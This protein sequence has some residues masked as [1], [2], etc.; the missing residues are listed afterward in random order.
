MCLRVYSCACLC[1][2]LTALS[3]NSTQS[4]NSLVELC[5]KLSTESVGPPG[6]GQCA[7]VAQN[8]VDLFEAECRRLRSVSVCQ[9]SP[10]CAWSAATQS[11]AVSG[12]TAARLLFIVGSV[13]LAVNLSKSSQQCGRMGT[14]SSAAG[15]ACA[16]GC[17]YLPSIEMCDA[18][19]DAFAS[20]VQPNPPPAPEPGA[21]LPNSAT[22][23]V[24]LRCAALSFAQ[25]CGHPCAWNQALKSCDAHPE[26]L[27]SLGGASARVVDVACQKLGVQQCGNRNDCTWSQCDGACRIAHSM[28]D[29][30]SSSTSCAEDALAMELASQAATKCVG[31]SVGPTTTEVIEAALASSEPG[32]RSFCRDSLRVITSTPNLCACADL[33]ALLDSWRRLVACTARHSAVPSDVLSLLASEASH[34]SDS[35]DGLSGWSSVCKSAPAAFAMPAIIGCES[36]AVQQCQSDCS[37]CDGNQCE[38]CLRCR[39]AL[40]CEQSAAATADARCICD[41]PPKPAIATRPPV[42]TRAVSA[43]CGACPLV[44]KQCFG[45]QLTFTTHPCGVGFVANANVFDSLTSSMPSSLRKRYDSDLAA[46]LQLLH[47][48]ASVQALAR[49]RALCSNEYYMRFKSL[50]AETS[51]W[52]GVCR[53]EAPTYAMFRGLAAAELPSCDVN[54]LDNGTLCANYSLSLPPPPALPSDDALTDVTETADVNATDAAAAQCSLYAAM[55]CCVYEVVSFADPEASMWKRQMELCNF[56]NITNV[57]TS[58]CQTASSYSTVAP[59]SYPTGVLYLNSAPVPVRFLMS[60]GLAIVILVRVNF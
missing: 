17:V 50:H 57:S 12:Q 20:R 34:C 15:P 42:T 29:G 18:D 16:D 28:L 19:P 56:Y 24:Q 22:D 4:G 32:A 3:D 54:D 14:H 5:S 1:A 6:P 27:L 21:K 33:G 26:V 11:C 31:T 47:P 23:S 41:Q 35:L 51:E 55:G 10:W 40:A 8:A 59:T 2:A 25:C 43:Q 52:S 9:L 46:L 60:T 37:A 38:T 7:A 39:P 36:A 45:P 49:I 13:E 44:R 53:A 30:A 48:L 58:P